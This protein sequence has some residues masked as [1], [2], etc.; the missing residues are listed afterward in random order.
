M[1]KT[2]TTILFLTCI[3]APRVAGAQDYT[4]SHDGNAS[5]AQDYTSGHDGN[6]SAGRDCTSGYDGNAP[7]DPNLK[8]QKTLEENAPSGLGQSRFAFAGKNDKFYMAL[9]GYAKV[10]ASYDFGSPL[11][12]PNEFITSEINVN[13]EPGNG[14]EVQF[15]A[16]QTFLGLN[17]VALPESEDKIGVFVGANFL[18]DYMPV[19]QHAYIKWRGLEAGYDYSLFSDTGC[20]PA[21]IDYEGPNAYTAIP[22]SLVSYTVRF[23]RNKEWTV[24][25]GVEKPLYSVTAGEGAGTVKQRVPDIPAYIK[26][27]WDG[28]NSWVRL[29]GILRNMQYRDEILQKNYNKVG[30]GV[31]LS[32]TASLSNF[33]TAYWQG[34]YGQGIASHI[35]DLCGMNMDM[36]PTGD[37]KMRCV[38][39]WGAF[40]GLQYNFSEKVFATTA[41]SHVRTYADPYK[42]GE[43][44]YG[45]QYRY[46]QY[47][48]ANVFWQVTPV[49]QTGLEYIYGRRVD[50]SGAQGHDNRIQAC[51]QVNF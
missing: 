40:V 5:A 13:P 49:I 6:A 11:D 14:G 22:T 7:A 44:S 51:V 19:L 28:D 29:S 20:S 12:N 17:F 18:K 43:I 27:S 37:G 32:G 9:C 4:S 31:Q 10:T 15:S 30:W 41:Y 25:A 42:G 48:T 46:A 23:G 8:M 39:A 50:Y 33:I 36:V 34:V 2:F 35:Q 21:T 3:L 47:A 45:D 16:M 1:K 26:Y 24:A 38:S